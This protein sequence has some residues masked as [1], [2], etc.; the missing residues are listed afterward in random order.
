LPQHLKAQG[1]NPRS[2][3]GLDLFKLGRQRLTLFDGLDRTGGGLQ[4]APQGRRLSGRIPDHCAG[5]FH[6]SH[7]LDA[8][9]KSMRKAGLNFNRCANQAAGNISSAS[10]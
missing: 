10:L 4:Q 5:F 1:L 6:V 2:Q 9:L 3:F 8:T 7:Q